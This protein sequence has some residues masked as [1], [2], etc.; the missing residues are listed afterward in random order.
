MP[1]FNTVANRLKH[2]KTKC[3]RE[4]KM[5]ILGISAGTHDPSASLLIDGKIIAAA[6]EERFIRE[7]HARRKTPVNAAKYCLHE[8]GITAGDLDV[9]AIP[10]SPR[11]FR[12]LRWRYFSRVF[13]SNPNRA[14]KALFKNRFRIKKIL[15]RLEMI[16]HQLGIDTKRTKIEFVEHHLAHAS[17]AYHLSG[18]ENAAIL[19]IDGMGEYTCTL[20]GEGEKGKICKVDEMIVPDS[21]GLFYSTLTEYLGFQSNNGEFKLMGMS[22][23]GDPEKID[24]SKLIQ[25]ENKKLRVNEDYIWVVKNK[26][27][28]G[29]RY[30]KEMVN[31]LGVPRTGDG[32][33]EPHIHIAAAT[34]RKF[35]EIVIKMLDDYLGPVLEKT[36]SLCFAGGCALNVRLNRKILQHPLVDRMYVQAAAHDAGLSLGASSYVAN[37]YGEKC[38]PMNHPYYGPQYNDA[39]ILT[40][41]DKFRIPRIRCEDAAQTAAD[42]LAQGH[43]VAWFQGRMEFGPRALGN[44]SILGHP[45]VNGV[46]D[47]IN[48]RIKFREK[49]RPFCPSVLEEDQMSVLGTEHPAPFMNLSFGVT[50]KYREIIPEVVHVDGS[51][52]AQTVSKDTNPLYHRLISLFKE[53][54]GIPVVLNT[55]LNRRGE[56][57]INSPEEAIAMLYGSGLEYM[58][59]GSYLIKK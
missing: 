49:W 58:V 35:E 51:L 13:L 11:I 53:K 43:I 59:M 8:A 14:L 4:V 6:E 33:S 37:Q 47:E 44:R 12:E 38:A 42:L 46:S 22:A 29:K 17:S 21:L 1:F 50:D 7:K 24:M 39:E 41:L 45:A 19:S 56:P 55:S 2:K 27:Y 54:T 32:L 40:A 3:S 9:I 57:M 20:F 52:R 10:F 26:K 16:I 30:S 36:R 5:K 31:L 25:Y 28:N 23:Y 18:F 15:K 34:Q 48:E